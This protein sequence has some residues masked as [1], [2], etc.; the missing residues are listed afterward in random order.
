MS[1]DSSLSLASSA[2][3]FTIDNFFFEDLL[4][5]N[6]NTLFLVSSRVNIFLIHI[7]ITPAYMTKHKHYGFVNIVFV[8]L[9]LFFFSY[10]GYRQHPL[11]L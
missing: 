4:L 1:S 3:S 8:S 7:R 9:S 6:S 10:P 2:I 11:Q 5:I